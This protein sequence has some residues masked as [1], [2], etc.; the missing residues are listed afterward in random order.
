[1]WPQTGSM[2]LSGHL[3]YGLRLCES[4]I[5]RELI[6]LG[7]KTSLSSP[8]LGQ[9]GAEPVEDDLPLQQGV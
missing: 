5:F 6:F 2:V 7:L 4:S 8:Q 9:G 1:M 3:P